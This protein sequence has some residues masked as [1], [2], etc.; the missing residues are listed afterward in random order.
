LT[1]TS[2]GNELPGYYL[3]VPAGHQNLQNAL[4]FILTPMEIQGD[5][6]LDYAAGKQRKVCSSLQLSDM[7]MKIK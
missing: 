1:A 3:G 7:V 4:S 2:P 6:P 5:F